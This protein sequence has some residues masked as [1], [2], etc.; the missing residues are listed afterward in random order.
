[1][2]RFQSRVH[3]WSHSYCPCYQKKKNFNDRTNVSQKVL[4]TPTSSHMRE[5]IILLVVRT[6]LSIL[7]N[8]MKIGRKTDILQIFVTDAGKYITLMG[9]NHLSV[10]VWLCLPNLPHRWHNSQV[11]ELVQ[12]NRRCKSEG[13]HSSCVLISWSW[14]KCKEK[15]IQVA[16]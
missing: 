7:E 14:T 3:Y 12:E 2:L 1:M 13:K 16:Y 11:F 8:E 6:L 4:K 9:S 5:L 15:K 10:L